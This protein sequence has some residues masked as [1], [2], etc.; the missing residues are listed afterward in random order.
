[1]LTKKIAI[2]Y[3]P[4]YGGNF[5]E[6]LFSLDSSTTP[7]WE[8]NGTDTPLSRVDSYIKLRQHKKIVHLGD[9]ELKKVSVN[10]S[11]YRYV[12][13]CVHPHE[14]DFRQ[15]P[16]QIF[17]VDLDWS[18]FSNYWLVE[19]KKSFDYQIARFRPD[20]TEKN[21]QI[22]ETYNTKIIDL[23][24]FLDQSRWKSE[25]QR[26]NQQLELPNHFDAADRLFA[27]W[28]NLRVSKFVNSFN[29][30]PPD[31]YSLYH[32]QRLKE[33]IWGAPDDWQVFYERVRDPQWPDCEQEKDFGLLPEWIQQEL[34]TVFGYQP[35]KQ[36]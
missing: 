22:Q 2:V 5:L 30:V 11:Q 18:D 15:S 33:A 25:Y 9:Y 3:L 36:V 13:E 32:H 28:Y 1:M 29:S 6:S 19:S 8:I 10:V 17:L 16:D 34:I 35:R 31:Q 21:L 23:N 27:F 24:C 7:L 14:F 26:I 20:E 4:G 12:V